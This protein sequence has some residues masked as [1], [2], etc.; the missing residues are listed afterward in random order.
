MSEDLSK[1]SYTSR[2]YISIFDDLK[3]SIPDVSSI[4][5]GNSESDPGIVLVKLMSMLGDMISYNQDKQTLE[6]FPRTVTQRKNAAQIFSLIGYKMHWYRSARCYVAITN[7]STK[8][9]TVPRFTRFTTGDESI[10]Y[11]N[12]SNQLEIASN[13]SNSGVEYNIELIQGIP[14]TPTRASSAIIADSNDHWSSIYNYNVNVEDII[15]NRIYL[16]DDKIDEDSF[17]LV[18]NKNE[19]WILCPNIDTNI[20]SGKYFD[21]RVDEYDK[22][23]L[24][25]VDYWD[26]FDVTNFKLFYLISAG[27]NGE[28]ASN[29]LSRVTTTIIGTTDKTAA[30]EDDILISNYESTYGYSPET[31]DE[32]RVESAK[33]V[34]TYDTLVT[35]DDFTRAVSRMNGVSKCIALDCT[36]DPGIYD[37]ETGQF[38][39]LDSYVVKIY[40]VRTPEY[41]DA[42]SDSYKEQ[43][44]TELMAYKLM[45]LSIIVDLESIKKYEWSVKG[46]VYLREP[47][48]VDKAND[49]LVKINNQLKYVYDSSRVDF[50]TPIKYIDVVE[51]IRDT[52]QMI[53]HVDIEPISYTDSL[54]G[55]TVSSG[56]ISGKCTRELEVNKEG[57]FKYEF[58]L[59]NEDEKTPIK[60]GT[61]NIKIN[62]GTY[63]LSDNGNGKIISSQGI[64]RNSGN[65]NYNTGL[66]SFELIDNI[67]SMTAVF[68]KNVIGIPSYVSFNVNNFSIS[69]ESIKK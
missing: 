60:P 3:S 24:Q 5:N 20:A 69:S 25:L 12:F 23:Y 18:D 14:R 30:S 19:E 50:N 64:L 42:D 35:L 7:T 61:V 67:S 40:I 26:R 41:E 1:L 37:E 31:P 16:N 38:R 52:D 34:N 59:L 55:E 36:N 32:A 43:I 9:I 2:D 21:F 68:N 45:P 6:V 27:E 44:K 53:Y 29:S 48:S 62:G 51:T 57:N 8:P 33:Y 46:E 13:N 54:T 39:A 17:I 22:P 11:T 47:V 28:I 65:I 58:S 49:I 56:D 63:I 66:V 4:W 15:D 10:T